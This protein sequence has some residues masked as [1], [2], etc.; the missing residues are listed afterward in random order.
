MP[1]LV[2]FYN[3]VYEV[4]SFFLTENS[5]EPKIPIITPTETGISFDCGKK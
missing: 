1:S 5:S 2:I 4:E 3:G